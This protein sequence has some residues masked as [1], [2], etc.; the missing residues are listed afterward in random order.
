MALKYVSPEELVTLLDER[1]QS[2]LTDDVNDETGPIID[3]E[4]LNTVLAHAE[5][6]AETFVQS[7]YAL[8]LKDPYPLAFVHAVLAIA[9]EMLYER[10]GLQDPVV[11]TSA[12]RARNWLQMV[13]DD[14]IDLYPQA[15]IEQAE[16]VYGFSVNPTF[17]GQFFL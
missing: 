3:P 10:R 12:T 5:S 8:P 6:L 11:E 1:A 9:R 17:D 15:E 7:R 4:L 13:K 16:V 2:Q 14:Q